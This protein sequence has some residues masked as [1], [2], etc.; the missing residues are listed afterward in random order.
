MKKEHLR[1]NQVLSEWLGRSGLSI[2]EFLGEPVPSAPRKSAP[3]H[4]RPGAPRIPFRYPGFRDSGLSP[5]YPAAKPA[6]AGDDPEPDPV[7]GVVLVVSFAFLG[8]RSYSIVLDQTGRLFAYAEIEDETRWDAIGQTE[9]CR[10]WW[11]SMRELMDVNAD[12]SPA[13]LPLREV[14]HLG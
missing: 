14:F 12:D 7:A 2:G 6:P 5:S 11:R 1:G 9:V 3:G 4:V 13:T 10:R 8:V